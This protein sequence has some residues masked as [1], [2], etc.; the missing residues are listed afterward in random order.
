MPLVILVTGL[1]ASQQLAG[2]DAVPDWIHDALVIANPAAAVGGC[3]AG[4]YT[5]AVNGLQPW[6]QAM[7]RW[8]TGRHVM[9]NT[10]VL[11]RQEGPEGGAGLSAL[12]DPDAEYLFEVSAFVSQ[13]IFFGDRQDK[14]LRLEAAVLDDKDK[15]IAAAPINLTAGNWAT[16]R[17][18][19]HSGRRHEVRCVVRAPSP[20]KLP[21]FY[22]AE[23]FRLTRKDQHWWSPQNLFDAPRTAVRLK[24]ERERLLRTM[25]PDVVGGHN[26]V[27]LNWDGY[28]TRRGIAVGGGQWEQEYN[29]LSSNDPLVEKFRDNGMACE[30]DGRIVEKRGLWL[31][32]NMCH[33]APRWHAYQRDRMVRI[34]PDVQLISQDNICAPSFEQ[35]GKGCFCRGCREGFR[36]WLLK[37]WTA[38]IVDAAGFDIVPYVESVRQSRIAKGRDAVLTDPVLRAFIQFHYASQLEHWRDNVRTASKVAGR[39]IVVCGNQWGGGGQRPY[40]VAVSQISHAAVVETGGAPLTPRNRAWDALATKLP[41]AAGDYRRP[42]WLYMTSLFHAAE[43]GRSRLRLNAA[44]AWADGGVP[45][46][47]ATAAGASGWFYDGEAAMCRFIQKHRALFARRERVANVGLVYS[48]P[49]LAWRQFRAFNLSAN[50]QRERFVA[51][52][53]LLEEAHVPYEV[54]CWWHPLLGDDRTAMDRL[55]RYQVLVLPGVDCFS[56]A[57]RA[58]VR[59]F[60]ARGGRVISIASPNCYDADAV[61]RP[62]GEKLAAKGERLIEVA[63]PLPAAL[64]RALGDDRMLETDAPNTVWANLWLDDTR[65]VFALHLVNGD[66]DLAVDRFRPVEKSKWRVKLPAGLKVTQAVVISPDEPDETKPLAVKAADGWATIVLSRLES[67]T[68]VAMFDGQALSTASDLAAA[69]RAVWR[70]SLIRGREDAASQRRL[71]EALSLLRSGRYDTGAALSLLP[72]D[73]KDSQKKR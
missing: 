44:Q 4:I 2:S 34:A 12:I 16:C 29:H 28:F 49:T 37:H 48:L 22:Y 62:A 5:P 31:G 47:W 73:H 30:A 51:W 36:A 43:A 65:H 67:Y 9:G 35:A 52:A 53:Q 13:G 54:N 38:G 26:G 46:P 59:A 42:V 60:Q 72:S 21:C 45:N 71:V 3:Q 50:T 61:P 15:V 19:F 23:D 18:T 69:R 39:P 14:D 32:F 64:E 40:S 24:D 56:D 33:N 6:R 55:N 41:M 63:Q 1:F 11:V 27:Y 68:V 25:D 70:T 66:V 57:Q 58:A 20:G 10:A 17:V 7:I 8:L